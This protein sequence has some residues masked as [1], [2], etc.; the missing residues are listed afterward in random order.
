M[1][2]TIYSFHLL[3]SYR[4][5]IGLRR[6]LTNNDLNRQIRNSPSGKGEHDDTKLQAHLRSST[7]IFFFHE[8][9]QRRHFDSLFAQAHDGIDLCTSECDIRDNG[10][11][12]F[13]FLNFSSFP[14]PATVIAA[15]EH[16]SD[17]E[18]A[19]STAR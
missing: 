7:Y 14:I 17:L 5:R 11:S 6:P 18:S 4:F 19:F 16:A 1:R 13:P 10:A 15:I 2:Y 8:T 3:R 12:L 9:R